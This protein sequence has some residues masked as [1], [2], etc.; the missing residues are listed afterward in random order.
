MGFLFWLFWA[1]DV[2]T[3]IALYFAGDFRR[4]F[5][6]NNPS[7]WVAVLF[8]LCVVAGLLFRLVFGRRSI[9]LMVVAMPLLVILAWYLI[10]KANGSQS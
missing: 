6:G 5:T 4:S 1:I 2:A 10:D 7:G 8:L 3:C 9:S